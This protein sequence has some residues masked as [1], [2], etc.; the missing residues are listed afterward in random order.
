MPAS[1]AGVRELGMT[2]LID[3]LAALG[4]SG[5]ISN[6]GRWVRL[7]GERCPVYVVET[8]WGGGYFTWCGLPCGNVVEFHRHPDAAIWAGLARAKMRTS[9]EAYQPP[10]GQEADAEGDDETR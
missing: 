2:Q 10:D 3:T 5:E 1:N 9:G 4:L 6:Q 7:S 8:S